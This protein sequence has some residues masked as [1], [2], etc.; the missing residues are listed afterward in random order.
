MRGGFW[1]VGNSEVVGSEEEANERW[2]STNE[3]QLESTHEIAYD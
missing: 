1:F 2:E 3:T